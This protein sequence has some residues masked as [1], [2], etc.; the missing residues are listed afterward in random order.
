LLLTLSLRPA[1]AAF[2]LGGIGSARGVFI[3]RF[4]FFLFLAFL[5]RKSSCRLTTTRFATPF[6]VNEEQLDNILS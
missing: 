2:L 4:A 5:R 1:A 3:E 6:H